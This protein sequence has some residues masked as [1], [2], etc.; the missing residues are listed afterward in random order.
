MIVDFILGVVSYLIAGV[1]F[2]L[3][4]ITVFPTSLAA[5]IAS[6]MA[7]INGWSWLFPVDTLLVVFGIL[8]LLVFVEFL[9]FTSMYIFSIIHASLRG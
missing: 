5:D 8:V 3:P 6:L 9:Y 4:T 2:L 1:T 7:Y